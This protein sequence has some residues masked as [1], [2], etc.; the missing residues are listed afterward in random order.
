MVIK[1]ITNNENRVPSFEMLK[2]NRKENTKESV[3]IVERKEKNSLN[4]SHWM[5]QCAP[6]SHCQEQRVA[7]LALA[8]TVFVKVDVALTVFVLTRIGREVVVT[9]GLGR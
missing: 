5:I 2:R 4:S 8:V 1:L 6:D 9:V 7:P 3:Q